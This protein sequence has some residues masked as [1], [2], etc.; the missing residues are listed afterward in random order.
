M[1]CASPGGHTRAQR[2]AD[3]IDRASPVGRTAGCKGAKKVEGQG[4]VLDPP[5]CPGPQPT[6]LARWSA[7]EAQ[8]GWGERAKQAHLNVGPISQ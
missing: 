4:R 6:V 7:G 3:R 1:K 2:P 5:P 8:Q